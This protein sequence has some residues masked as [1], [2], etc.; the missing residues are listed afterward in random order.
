M[1]DREHALLGEVRDLQAKLA[2]AERQLARLDGYLIKYRDEN[3]QLR[4]ENAELERALGLN[5]EVAV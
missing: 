4:A 1:T 3:N 2:V 5:E